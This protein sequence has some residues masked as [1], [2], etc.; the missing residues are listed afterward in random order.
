MKPLISIGTAQFGLNYG[1]TNNNGKVTKEEVEK[2]LNNQHKEIEYLD[3][4]QAY[5]DA[6]KVL[7]EC[8]TGKNK[9]KIVCKFPKQKNDFF[10]SRDQTIWNTSFYKSLR[11][12]KVNKIDT[13]LIHSSS[14]LNKRGREVLKDWLLERKEKGEVDR[15]GLSIYES[16]ELDTMERELMDVIQLPLSLYDQRLLQDKTIEN[17]RQQGTAIHARSLYLQGLLLN[18][19]DK[20]PR[21]VSEGAKKHHRELE[22]EA[23]RRNC[24]LIDMALGFAKSQEDLEAVV[25]GICKKSE[26]DDLIK[27]WRQG[28]PW[29]Q[30]EWN[31]WGIADRSIVDP[32]YWPQ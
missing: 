6:E 10:E 3:T 12:L 26:M 13:L 17:L 23:G 25:L 21:W 9:F 27:A 4:A 14:D 22:K 20:W 18:T 30:Y 32:R 7:G 2:I 31:S 11:E 28:S 16:R 8:L 19:T 15:I 29:K 5:G 1:I 24:K